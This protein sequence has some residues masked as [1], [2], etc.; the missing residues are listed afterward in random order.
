M[1]PVLIA[2]SGPRDPAL[3][4]VRAALAERVRLLPNAMRALLQLV[5]WVPLPETP[6][7]I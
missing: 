4:A 3:T 6:R 1:K 5:A 2:S 7:D